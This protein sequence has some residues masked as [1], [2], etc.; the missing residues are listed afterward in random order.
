MK[1]RQGGVEERRP[2]DP[3]HISRFYVGSS[4]E[5]DVL[6]P[7]RDDDSRP[8]EPYSGQRLDQGPSGEGREASAAGD[9][10]C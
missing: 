9:S 4:H 2:G 1:G 7:G 6:K 10:D 5:T 3:N 8:R